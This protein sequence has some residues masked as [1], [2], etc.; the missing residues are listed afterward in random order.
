MTALD[1]A[2]RRTEVARLWADFEADRESHLHD[3]C[4][5]CGHIDCSHAGGACYDC[6]RHCGWTW[7]GE[8]NAWGL[9]P[10]WVRL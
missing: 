7:L 5:G 10:G 1:D 4:P 6:V 2:A 8:G 9:P 3:P